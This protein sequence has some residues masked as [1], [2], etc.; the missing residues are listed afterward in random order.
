MIHL[1]ALGLGLLAA[2]VGFARAGI[3]GALTGVVTVIG[4]SSG[5]AVALG[6]QT[7]GAAG[8]GGAEISIWHRRGG[9]LAAVGCVLAATYIG[10]RFGW[11]GAIGGY[12]SGMLAGLIA[13]ALSVALRRP[14]RAGTPGRRIPI[15]DQFDLGN[16]EDVQLIDEIRE[17]FSQMLAHDTGPYRNCVFRPAVLL[18]YPKDAIRKALTALLDF[19]EGRAVSPHLDQEIRSTAVADTLRSCLALLDNYLD[20]PPEALPTDPKQNGRVGAAYLQ[21]RSGA[22]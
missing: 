9:F 12:A 7:A 5:L 6:R 4:A 13:S 20:L 18:P 22:G 15:P 17:R 21:G 2:L 8:R 19:A 11:L 1:L 16:A 3:L 14:Q 10:W